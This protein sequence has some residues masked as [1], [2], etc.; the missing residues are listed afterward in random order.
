MRHLYLYP[1]II[2]FGAGLFAL[3]AQAQT[4]NRLTV[5]ESVK[6]GLEHSYRL[7]AA[8]AEVEGAE[9]A[10]R[11]SRSGRLPA[12]RGQASYM[13]L[14]DN[15]P[16]VDYELP[17]M[18]TTYTLLPV[19]LDRFYTEL[20]V[21]QLLFA[22]GRLNKRIEA[23]DHQAEAAGLMEKQERVEVA[24]Q[25]REAY[26]NLYRAQGAHE[27]LKSAQERVYTHLRNVRNRVE[28]GAALQTELLNAKTRRSEVRLDQVESRSRVKVARLELNRLLGLP[29][30]AQTVPAAPDEPG[31]SPF[32][33]REMK[34]RAPA[35][36]PDL[37]ALSERVEAR[38]AEID[39]V[40]G[41]WFPQVS[42]VGRYVYARPNQYFFAEQDQFRGTWEA[43]V[44]LQWNIWSG[45]QRSAEA[46]R[47][48]AQLRKAEAQLADRRSQARVEISRQYL[49]LERAAEAI[50]VAASSV[51]AAR[52]AF[53][54]ARR[55]Y[56]EGVALSEQ[57]LD[58]EHAYRKAQARQ[59][60]AV[61]DYEIARA[62]VLSA[63]GQIW[64]SDGG[65]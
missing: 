48:R 4:G 28:E 63:R 21:E 33:R 39:A 7:R 44:R 40:Q 6:M 42:L 30:D 32:G 51:D 11:Q 61:A 41:E 20:S 27:V 53:Q 25:V 19:E 13:R 15:I 24:F 58:A 37:Q 46:S 45:G 3:P 26:W 9:A 56:E 47:A 49:E 18:D 38:E 5:A 55:E 50:E 31:A 43:G 35:Q 12:I 14:S 59:A 34:E 57:V 65:N 8:G 1:V 2:W 64:G 22:G 10:Y 62:A 52:E 29:G 23:A 36:R 60:E 17:G 54:S 16:E